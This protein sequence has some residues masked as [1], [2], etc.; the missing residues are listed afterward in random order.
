MNPLFIP[1]LLTQG[2]VFCTSDPMP[3]NQATSK[4]G[5]MVLRKWSFSI[6]GFV[7]LKFWMSSVVV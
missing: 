6:L 7:N 3:E 1:K 5:R 2:I 4:E